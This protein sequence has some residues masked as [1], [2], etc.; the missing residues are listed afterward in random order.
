[1][2]AALALGALVILAKSLQPTSPSN[3]TPPTTNCQYQQ[4]GLQ[5][6][7]MSSMEHARQDGFFRTPL[8]AKAVAVEAPT[9]MPYNHGPLLP[10]VYYVQHPRQAR[11]DINGASRVLYDAR[12]NSVRENSWVL[13]PDGRENMRRQMQNSLPR[14]TAFRGVYAEH[15]PEREFRRMPFF[16]NPDVDGTQ[17]LHVDPESI[18]ATYTKQEVVKIQDSLPRTRVLL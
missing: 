11:A 7:D 13:T 16:N 3:S 4:M 17:A 15:N 2:D 14:E 12:D 8:G 18:R 5:P 6:Q 9:Q 1:M 10:S